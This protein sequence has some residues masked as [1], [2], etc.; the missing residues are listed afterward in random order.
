MIGVSSRVSDGGFFLTLPLEICFL[1][2]GADLASPAIFPFLRHGF[3]SESEDIKGMG[4]ID[5]SLENQC[6]RHF[7]I[8]GGP[9]IKLFL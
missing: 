8:K 9:K 4:L 2:V 3:R 7:K 5:F 1:Q 6:L